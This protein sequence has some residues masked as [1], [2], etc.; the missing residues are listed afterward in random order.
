MKPANAFPSSMRFSEILHEFRILG[1]IAINVDC[2]EGKYAKGLFSINP[3]KPIKIH[4][5]TNLLIEPRHIELNT[6][7]QITLSEKS[8]KDKRVKSFY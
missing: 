5:P 7:N 1:G 4:F 3:K 6:D 2:R 8:Q